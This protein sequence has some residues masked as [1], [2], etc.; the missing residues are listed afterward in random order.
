MILM[1]D[2]VGSHV[3]ARLG[4]CYGD[5]FGMDIQSKLFNGQGSELRVHQTASVDG[6]TE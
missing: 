6:F 1:L 5:G 2:P 4:D 3:A